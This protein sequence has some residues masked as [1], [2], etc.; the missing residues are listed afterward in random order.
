MFRRGRAVNPFRSG[1]SG[2]GPVE[3]AWEQI[4][5]EGEPLLLINGLG[6][7][8]VAYELGFCELLANAGFAVARFD[9][10]DVGESTRCQG[11]NHPSESTYDITDMARDAVAVLDDLGWADAVVLGQSMGGMIAQQLVI[12]APQRVR[13]M[14]SLMSSTGERGFGA[15]SKEAMAGLMARA[16]EEREAWLDH[17]VKTEQLWA[18][19]EQWDPTWARAKGELLFDHGVDSDGAG[20]QFKAVANRSRDAALAGVSTP[21]LV[22]HGSADTLITPSGG[23][24]T[25]DVIPDARYVEIDGMGHDLHP[26]FW[27]RLVDEVAA[28]ALN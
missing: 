2:P 19:P 11:D 9:N 12:D 17:R 16:P 3:L 14:I 28:F 27:Q 15:P 22:L 7:P 24:H 23:R 4:N 18:S 21:T 5:E 8:R 13:S 10:R 26:H 25:A 6:S 1:D 20:R